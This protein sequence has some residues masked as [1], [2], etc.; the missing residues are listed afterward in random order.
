MSPRKLAA[1]YVKY[2][3]TDYSVAD[4]APAELQ[5]LLTIVDRQDRWMLFDVLKVIANN[6]TAYLPDQV[7]LLEWFARHPDA[8]AQ[9]DALLSSKTPPK[10]LVTLLRNGYLATSNA[11]QSKV[12][13]VLQSEIEKYS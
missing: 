11:L 8:V 9:C 2:F 3:N 1:M 4:N 13:A 7:G 12:R 6:T 5:R 10:N